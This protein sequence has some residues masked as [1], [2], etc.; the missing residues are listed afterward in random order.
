VT[1]AEYVRNQHIHTKWL[2]HWGDTPPA[3]CDHL[4]PWKVVCR[5]ELDRPSPWLAGSRYLQEVCPWC[6]VWLSSR[7]VPKAAA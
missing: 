2:E 1:T 3:A 5:V 6:N 7:P 4:T